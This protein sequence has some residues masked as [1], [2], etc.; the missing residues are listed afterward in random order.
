MKP[1][2]VAIKDIQ[3]KAALRRDSENTKSS[4]NTDKEKTFYLRKNSFT[5]FNACR[6]MG[7]FG[8]HIKQVSKK[9]FAQSNTSFSIAASWCSNAIYNL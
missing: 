1:V 7:S 2:Q 5:I 6:T 8:K 3:F 9:F 4:F